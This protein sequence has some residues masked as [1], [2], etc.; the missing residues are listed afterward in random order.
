M[1][2]VPPTRRFFRNCRYR[3]NCREIKFRCTRRLQV[4]DMYNNRYNSLSLTPNSRATTKD[5]SCHVLEKKQ[6]VTIVNFKNCQGERC[7]GISTKNFSLNASV[8]FFWKC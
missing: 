8:N 1:E 3:Q 2:I 5:A 6:I 7:V 4:L